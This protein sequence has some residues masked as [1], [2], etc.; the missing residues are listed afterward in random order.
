V[1]CHLTP[2]A[3]HGA[4]HDAGATQMFGSSESV[5]MPEGRGHHRRRS[6]AIPEETALRSGK[7]LRYKWHIKPAMILGCF[8]QVADPQFFTFFRFY[9]A[10]ADESAE[11]VADDAEPCFGSYIP[12]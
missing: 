1:E 11:D 5:G 12:P 3:Q 6:K 4:I 8:D 9:M 7:S 2:H 10:L